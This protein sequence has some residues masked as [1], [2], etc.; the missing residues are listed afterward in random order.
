MSAG[1]GLVHDVLALLLAPLAS[2]REDVTIAAEGLRSPIEV[3]VWRGPKL[4]WAAAE[5]AALVDALRR[6]SLDSWR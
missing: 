4:T 3:I 1:R 5:D 6:E 2:P